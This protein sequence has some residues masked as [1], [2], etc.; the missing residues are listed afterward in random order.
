[1]AL[2]L[3]DPRRHA[4][5]QSRRGDVA[6]T[7]CSSRRP[8]TISCRSTRGPARSAGTSRSPSFDEQYFSTMAPI[9]VGNHVLVGT[10]NDLDTPGFLQS[11]DPE[12]GKLQWKFY[13]VPMNPGDPGLDTWPSLDAA[14]HGGGQT[15]IPG[16]YDPETK[17]YIFGTGNPD[18]RLHRPGPQ[19][20]QP[21]HLLAGRGQRRHRQDGVVLPDV[22][23]RHARLGLGADA[24][25]DR[26][27]RSTA[28]RA[29]WSRPRRATATSSPSIASPA[30]TSSPRKFGDDDQLGEGRCA[31]TAR[32]SRTP[33]RKRRFRARSCRRSKA[34]STNWPPPA[35]SPETGLF[36]VHENNG[37]NIAL[38][39]RPG[40][41]R[42]DGAR[43]ASWRSASARGGSALT[44]IDS[45]DRQGGVAS[46][47]AARRRRRRPAC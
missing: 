41:A 7:T 43:R 20:R 44:A 47:M 26:R 24:D 14:R 22:A 9:V 31:R 33:R 28:G 13:T 19:G 38:P 32:R 40:S 12:T 16:V 34:A 2:L 3:E 27:R 11:F 37:F 15:W 1:M 30:S 10:G 6:A 29:S 45:E 39:D 5:R 36:Y 18:A 25:P 42:L 8:T 17:L 46:R 21:L 35:Y 23:A 4:H